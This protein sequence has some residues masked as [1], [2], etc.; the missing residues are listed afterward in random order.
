LD[1]FWL[2]FGILLASCWSML[3]HLAPFRR[4]KTDPAPNDP[5]KTILIYLF[6][7]FQMFDCFPFGI[8]SEPNFHLLTAGQ[9]SLS[10]CLE[11]NVSVYVLC[12]LLQTQLAYLAVITLF[13]DPSLGN[14]R[15]YERTP[16]T[17]CSSLVVLFVVC[18]VLLLFASHVFFT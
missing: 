16:F 15:R 6:R 5:Q 12:F 11:P 13:W 17:E 9:R 4:P 1:R 3:V 14:A 10:L 7:F 18:V 8:V 2:P